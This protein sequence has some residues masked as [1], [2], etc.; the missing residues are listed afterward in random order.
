MSLAGVARIISKTQYTEWKEESES[1]KAEVRHSTM[2][3]KPVVADYG[4][5]HRHLSRRDVVLRR[6]I[7][8]LG[9][10]TLRHDADGFSVLSRAIVAQQI[11]TKAARS[12]TARLKA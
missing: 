9:P 10:C 6:L 2:K 3:D 7:K 8:Q 11:S 5:A 12:I 4:H 1:R